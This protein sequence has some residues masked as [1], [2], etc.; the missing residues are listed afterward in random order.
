MDLGGRGADNG[1][2]HSGDAIHQ[3]PSLDRSGEQDNILCFTSFCS[4]GNDILEELKLPPTHPLPDSLPLLWYTGW[5]R[6]GFVV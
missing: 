5:W 4:C 2:S 3:E 1:V 6:V